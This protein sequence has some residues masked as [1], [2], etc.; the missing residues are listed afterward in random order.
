MASPVVRFRIDFDEHSSVGPGKISLLE[1]IRD[2][3]SLSQAARNIGMSYRRAWLLV[4]SLKQ[5][6]REPVT[7]ASRGGKGR[8]GMHVTEFGD[9]LIR[10][11]RDLERDFAT[12]AERRLRPLIATVVRHSQSGGKVSV[13]GKA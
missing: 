6:F 12:L 4:E 8:G 2:A 1:A 3:H 9:A 5:S 10:N 11:Y 13:R 7:V